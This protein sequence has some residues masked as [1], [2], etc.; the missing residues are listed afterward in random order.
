MTATEN[1][2]VPGIGDPGEV[3]RDRHGPIDRFVVGV[4]NRIAWAFPILMGVI[5]AQI[6]LRRIGL[7]QAWLEDMQW[8]LYGFTMMAGM[9]YA[10]TTGSHV[11]VDI[12]HRHYSDEKKAR[13]EA[14][15]L[16]WMLLPFCLVMTDILMH[17]A[18]SSVV[19]REGSDSPN[20][21]HGLYYLKSTLPVLF[22]F[23]ALAGWAVYLRNLKLFAPGNPGAMLIFAFPSAVF[24]LWRLFHYAAYWIVRLSNP[25][26]HP[27]RVS[28]EPV[29]DFLLPSAFAVIVLLLIAARVMAPR[30][31][32]PER[33]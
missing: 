26:I 14:I 6:A 23:A 20:G 21:L 19:A 31:A 29:F 10:V 5:V 1:T 27:R 3:D 18:F 4:S 25:D 22:V 24:L 15:A 8:W 9:A 32:K 12:F 16:G 7:G 2:S 11:R 33:R 13:L 28:R 17:Y 30:G